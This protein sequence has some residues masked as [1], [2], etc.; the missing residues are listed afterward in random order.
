[1]TLVRTF[2]D[3]YH[4]ANDADAL[5]VLQIEVQR[6]G[7]S[8]ADVAEVADRSSPP[9]E[10]TTGPASPRAARRSRC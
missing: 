9:A 4:L 3:E 8:G 5:D 2:V 7:V 6:D 1:M 10:T